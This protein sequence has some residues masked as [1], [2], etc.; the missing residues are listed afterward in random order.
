MIS[1]AIPAYKSKYMKQAID[2]VLLQSY[3]NFS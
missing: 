2:S 3:E 1:V